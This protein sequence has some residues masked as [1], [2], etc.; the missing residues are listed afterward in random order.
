MKK[1]LKYFFNKEIRK[2]RRKKALE[3][4]ADMLFDVT[5]V[6]NQFWF[7]YGGS[8]VAPMN[9]LTD[10]TDINHY[11]AIISMIRELYVKRNMP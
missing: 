2:E 3:E 9:M 11:S 7:C 6:D 1:I 4:R 8:L 5:L 10:K